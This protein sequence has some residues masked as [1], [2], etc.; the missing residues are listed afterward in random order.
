MPT[1]SAHRSGRCEEV[2]DAG[3]ERDAAAN[4]Q[5]G[6]LQKRSEDPAQHE[7]DNEAQATLVAFGESVCITWATDRPSEP[8]FIQLIVD[9]CRTIALGAD[10]VVRAGE[11]VNTP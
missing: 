8:E 1:V 4:D 9:R 11:S 2:R 3:D 7:S 10:T 6:H 5:R